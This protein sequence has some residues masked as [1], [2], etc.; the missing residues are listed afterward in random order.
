MTYNVEGIFLRSDYSEYISESF[1]KKYNVDLTTW[2]QPYGFFDEFSGTI[3][4]NK[5][6]PDGTYIILGK[7][8]Y[9]GKSR[10][11]KY[12]IGQFNLCKILGETLEILNKFSPY[13]NVPEELKSNLHPKF[14]MFKIGDASI[15]KTLKKPFNYIGESNLTVE[16]LMDRINKISSTE[17]TIKKIYSLKLALLRDLGR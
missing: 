12:I 8:S 1:V 4:H 9:P 13:P 11:S 2:I 3:L 5:D 7:V 14:P 16:E 15:F 10:M 6:L 17:S